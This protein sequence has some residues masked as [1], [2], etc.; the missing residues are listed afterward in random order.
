MVLATT[1]IA[2]STIVACTKLEQLNT[3]ELQSTK[4]LPN[5][6]FVMEGI[7]N[8]DTIQYTGN[9]RSNVYSQKINGVNRGSVTDY[10]TDSIAVTPIAYG[11][12]FA[13]SNNASDTESY[14]IIVNESLTNTDTLHFIVLNDSTLLGTFKMYGNR[15][16]VN[17]VLA[18]NQSSFQRESEVIETRSA[19]Y[20]KFFD[21]GRIRMVASAILDE[22][23]I[24]ETPV[25]EEEHSRAWWCYTTI[26][27]HV[28]SC[29]A[30][31]YVCHNNNHTNC[32]CQCTTH[33]MPTI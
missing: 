31:H 1:V 33:V 5:I 4:S 17:T 18:L 13:L 6:P 10:S 16:F 26:S 2:V 3:T 30:N 22:I 14:R 20:F 29:P 21:G 7:V 8:G 11:V 9:Y 28:K 23:P 25:E 15:N 24:N 19:P 27:G 32:T 12:E